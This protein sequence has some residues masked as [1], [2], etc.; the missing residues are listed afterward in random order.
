MTEVAQHN[1]ATELQPVRHAAAMQ[2]RRL[3]QA[4]AVTFQV[5]LF[6]FIGPLA[7]F[8][9]V[10]LFW[11]DYY[12]IPTCYLCWYLWDIPSATNGGRSGP[13][14]HWVRS[15]RVWKLNAAYYPVTLVKTADLDPKKNHLVCCHPHGILCFGAVTAFGADSC[16]LST[17]FP[18]ILTRICTLQGTFL[19]P[20]FRECLLIAGGMAAS[21]SS[22]EAVLSKPGGGEAP[23]LMV[24]GVPEMMMA[25]KPDEIQLHLSQRKGFVK[26]AMEVGSTLVPCFVFGETETYNQSGPLAQIWNRLTCSVR[27]CFGIAPVFFSGAGWAQGSLGFLPRRRKLKV[28]MGKPMEFPKVEK[29]SPEQVD[30]A[31][32]QYMAALA[33]LYLKHN[34]DES[35][36]LVIT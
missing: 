24:G 19:L 5:G 9:L 22:L 1:E 28:V 35:V 18:G 15:W 12:L 27:N 32:K 14:V 21:R 23:I 2:M 13:W 26:M 3:L 30:A 36:S 25:S 16:G 20:L 4:A 31:H 7:L 34:P 10:S 17:L 8:F 33:S 29:A 11:T 6:L